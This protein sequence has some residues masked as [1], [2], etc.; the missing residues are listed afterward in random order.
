MDISDWAQMEYDQVAFARRDDE[1]SV[2]SHEANQAKIDA[3]FSSYSGDVLSAMVVSLLGVLRN[4]DYHR[5]LATIGA[6]HEAASEDV[7]GLLNR[8]RRR[9]PSTISDLIKGVIFMNGPAE[10]SNASEKAG[11]S[12]L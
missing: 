8:G 2:H 7:V 5:F 4:N 1:I 12:P 9:P 6:M 3:E 11:E 10:D